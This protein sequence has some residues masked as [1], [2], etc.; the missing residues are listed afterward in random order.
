MAVATTTSGI[1]TKVEN[2]TTPPSRMQYEVGRSDS[3]NPDEVREI[4]LLPLT[5]PVPQVMILEKVIHWYEDTLKDTKN[6]DLK[7]LFSY[8][9]KQ[10]RELLSYQ[11]KDV[12]K[13]VEEK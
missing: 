12:P 1:I 2:I 3:E 4:P 13:S 11:Y 8:T 10:L 6:A 7:V 9:V 5:V